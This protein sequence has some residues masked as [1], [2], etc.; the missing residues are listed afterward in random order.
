[1]AIARTK[2][3]VA[4]FV[5][6][7]AEP[8]LPISTAPDSLPPPSEQQ[9]ATSGPSPACPQC[10]APMAWVEAHLR[11]YCKSCKMYF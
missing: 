1:T 2:T 3:P 10:E 4:P 5:A 9:A 11:F 8:K 6:P 7:T